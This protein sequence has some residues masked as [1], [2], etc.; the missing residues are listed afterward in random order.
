LHTPTRG[1]FLLTFAADTGRE[2]E[3]AQLPEPVAADD[4]ATL[5]SLAFPKAA[6]PAG[7]IGFK[8]KIPNAGAI[9]D[10]Q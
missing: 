5:F 10:R 7:R 4:V 1:A 9:V 2:T 6:A 3:P 8:V